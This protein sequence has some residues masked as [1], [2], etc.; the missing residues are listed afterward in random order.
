MALRGAG[1]KKHHI[2]LAYEVVVVVILNY[3][4]QLVTNFHLV[5]VYRRF[6]SVFLLLMVAYGC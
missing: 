5:Q 2:S 1:E 6:L 3:V 4:Y